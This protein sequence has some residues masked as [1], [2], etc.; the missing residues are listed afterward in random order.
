ML[1]GPGDLVRRRIRIEFWD[2]QGAKHT[3]TVDGHLSREKVARIL[4]Y[5]ELMGASSPD[6]RLQRVPS[7]RRK[8][9]RIWD[10]VVTQFREKAFFISTDVKALYEQVYGEKI[11]HSTVSTYLGRLK[12]RGLLDRTGSPG[13]WRYALRPTTHAE[14]SPFG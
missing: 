8:V 13:E 3:L 6:P 4:D 14:P 7:V 12:D 9:D 11:S 5:V 2:H 1:A 10:L